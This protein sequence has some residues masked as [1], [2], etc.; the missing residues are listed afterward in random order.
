MLRILDP[1]TTYFN[2][3]QYN[4]LMIHT[5]GK[6]GGLGIQIAIRNKVLTVMTPIGGTPASRAGLHRRPDHHHRRQIHAGHYH[7]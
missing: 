2:V 6:F 7:R 1:H 5:E 4:E 3:D